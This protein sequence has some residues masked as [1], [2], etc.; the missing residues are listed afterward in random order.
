MTQGGLTPKAW[1][2]LTSC[3]LMRFS[4]FDSNKL[5]E[6]MHKTTSIK[7]PSS[8]FLSIK[9]YNRTHDTLVSLSFIVLAHLTALNLSLNFSSIN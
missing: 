4:T 1:S 8:T 7:K 6:C 5:S 3:F 2:F 9:F